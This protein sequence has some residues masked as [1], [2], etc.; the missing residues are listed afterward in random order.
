MLSSLKQALN[1][2]PAG[3]GL[4]AITKPMGKK[5]QGLAVE[6][7]EKNTRVTA[8]SMGFPIDVTRAH[9]DFASLWLAKTWL[10]EHRASSAHL[11]Q[12][13]RE[14]RGMNYG[15]YAYIEAF[16]GG[17]F[18]FF[19]TANRTRQSQLFEIWIR[20]VAPENA[21]LALRIAIAELDKLVP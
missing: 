6:I 2:L 13:I 7:I 14:V 4:P 17:M 3:L 10:G 20:P 8:I 11:Y 1:K 15:D 5:N 18:Q 12:R 19:P 16:P 21:H 9:P